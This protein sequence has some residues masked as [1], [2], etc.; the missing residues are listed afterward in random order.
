MHSLPKLFRSP[1]NFQSIA[2]LQ[3]NVVNM[4]TPSSSLPRANGIP[5]V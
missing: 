1:E 5:I 2:G 4:K 3:G